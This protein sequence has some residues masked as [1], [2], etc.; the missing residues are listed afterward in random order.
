MR[1]FGDKEDAHFVDAGLSFDGGADVTITH[2]SQTDPVV[3]T[4]SGTIAPTN[5]WAVYVDE[6]VGM[7]ELNGRGFLIANVNIGAKTFE[8]SGEDGTGYGAYVQGGIYRRVVNEVS[9]L[10]H[11]EGETVAVCGDGADEGNKAVLNGSITLNSYYNKIH[12]GLPFTYTLTPLPLEVQ[13][14]TGSASGL[15]KRVE[16]VR[17]RLYETIGGMCG[18]DLDSLEDIQFDVN[19]ELYTGDKEIEFDGDYDAQA[20]ITVYHN[21]PLP[22]TVLAIMAQLVTYDR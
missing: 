2:T 15:N 9:G 14:A 21:Q 5:G 18:P 4:Y 12:A 8:L 1:D 3:V 16:D 13:S 11:L 20:N 22:I 17:L 19:Q 10:D 6:V 7:D